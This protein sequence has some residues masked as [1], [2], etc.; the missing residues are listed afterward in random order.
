MMKPLNA[1]SVVGFMVVRKPSLNRDLAGRGAYSTL[2]PCLD[3]ICYGGIDRMPWFEIGEQL[4]AG[5]LPERIQ[6]ERQRIQLDNR[7][8]SGV[9]VCRDLPTAAALLRYSNDIYN[10][11]ELIAVRSDALARL[12]GVR[13]VNPVQIE[14]LGYDVVA[15]GQGSLLSAG[16]FGVPAAFPGWRDRLNSFGVLRSEDLVEPYK[17]AYD[18]AATRG[19]VEDITDIQGELAGIGYAVAGI[20]IGRVRV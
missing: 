12:K 3:N 10:A 9:E 4:Y 7:D 18:A 1:D 14:W 5:T 2:A 13:Q 19:E 11:N 17:A 16:L 15:L 6:H 20:E 8:L